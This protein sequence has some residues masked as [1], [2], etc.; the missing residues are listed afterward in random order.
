MTNFLHRIGADTRYL[1]LGLPMTLVAFSL[2]VTGFSAGI[3]TAVV[4][5]GLLVLSGT[6][7]M[8]RGFAGIE[9]R[10]LPE[11]T[12]RPAL[13]PY[14]APPPMGAGWFRTAVHPLTCGQNWLD[15]AHGIVKFP[16][17]V[18][19]FSVAVTWWTGTVVGLL[20]PAYGWILH[21]LQ[22]GTT[23]PELIGLGD[24]LLVDNLFNLAIGVL[25]A[26]TLPFVLRTAALINAG[27]GQAMLTASEEYVPY[28][29]PAAYA[30][31]AG[32]GM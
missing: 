21:G 25:F 17:A 6:L 32:H 9:R 4:F 27:L 11:V 20:Y 1:I 16:L 28:Q 26:V 10:L 31:M 3:G 12:G 8:A 29:V 5:V 23:L 18:A 15:L 24:T 7:L 13:R 19:G 14:Y 30:P 2:L 22:V